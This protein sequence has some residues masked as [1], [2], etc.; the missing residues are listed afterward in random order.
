[1]ESPLKKEKA[2]G[3]IN[4]EKSSEENYECFI[5]RLTRKKETNT[6]VNTVSLM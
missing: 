4:I 6:V 1:M 2:Q 3:V 5:E